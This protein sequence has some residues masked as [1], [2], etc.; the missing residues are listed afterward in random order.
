MTMTTK[1]IDLSRRN[2]L[3]AS[4]S[5][6]AGL[7]AFNM[8]K[9]AFAANVK[10]KKVNLLK[11]PTN[12]IEVAQNSELVQSAWDYLLKQINS[13]HDTTLR[14]QVLDL[15]KNTVP[16]FMSLYPTK[17]KVQAV[18]DKLLQNGLVDPKLTPI[19]KIFPPL[20]DLNTLPQPFFS[21][22]GSG[23]ASH[24]SYPGGLVT[25]TAVNVEI[26]KAIVETYSDIMEYDANYDISVAGQLLHD[27]AKPWVFQWQQDGSS[28]PEYTIAG[29]GAHHVFSIAEVIFRGLPKDEIIAQACAHNHPGSPKDEAQVVGWIKAAAILAGK[30]PIALGLLSKDGKT[31]PTHH[32]HAGYIVHLGDHD[33]VLSVPVAKQSVELLKAVAVKE[34]GFKDNELNTLKFNAFRNYIAAQYSFMRLHSEAA[35][36]DDPNATV[37]SIA[38]TIISK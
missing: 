10:V 12:P 24:H 15:Y 7:V 34:Y 20:K 18:Y 38:K 11:L 6:A 1:N 35:N 5:V 16:T 30:D 21:A 9:P 31:L 3:K 28:L 25:H 36:A 22:P 33:F 32:K 8:V 17:D 14:A 37:A 29:T 2:F 19:D 23:Y 27:L 26:T 4:A 13:L